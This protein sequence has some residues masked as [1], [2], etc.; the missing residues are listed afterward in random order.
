MPRIDLLHDSCH[1]KA[2]GLREAAE[3][4]RCRGRFLD[5]SIS[6]FLNF[7]FCILF[8]LACQVGLLTRRQVF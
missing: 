8:S 1:K 4:E 3:A 5:F 7:P 2:Q 6:R